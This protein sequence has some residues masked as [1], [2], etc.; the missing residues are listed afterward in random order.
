MRESWRDYTD[1]SD[2]RNGTWLLDL[3]DGVVLFPR[4]AAYSEQCQRYYMQIGFIIDAEDILCKSS[5]V[6]G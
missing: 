6:P 1:P 4:E 5:K 3:L 2:S